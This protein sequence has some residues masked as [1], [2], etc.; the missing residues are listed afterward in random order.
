MKGYYHAIKGL[1]KGEDGETDSVDIR[2][3]RMFL[4]DPEKRFM[5]L[6]RQIVLIA[7]TVE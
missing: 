7:N 5:R 2:I 4:S 1:L 6:M 3:A